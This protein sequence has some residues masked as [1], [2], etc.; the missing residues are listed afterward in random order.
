LIVRKVFCLAPVM[1][2]VKGQVQGEDLILGGSDAYHAQAPWQVRVF[3][4]ESMGVPL[5]SSAN[6]LTSFARLATGVEHCK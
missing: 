4:N 6:L 5:I 3:F 2:Q 1:R